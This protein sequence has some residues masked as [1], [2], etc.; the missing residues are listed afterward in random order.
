[1]VYMTVEEKSQQ[2]D[3]EVSCSIAAIAEKEKV[4]NVGT[5]LTL[6]FLLSLGR[7]FNDGV[8]HI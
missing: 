3:P 2:K 6:S 8:A 7:H 4:K 5:Q 1:M